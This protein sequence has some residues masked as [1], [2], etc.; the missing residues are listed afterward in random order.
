MAVDEVKKP[1]GNLNILKESTVIWKGSSPDFYSD[2]L[3]QII[4]IDA[5]S[6]SESEYLSSLIGYPMICKATG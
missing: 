2:Y 5:F 4:G 3:T 6:M 1:F